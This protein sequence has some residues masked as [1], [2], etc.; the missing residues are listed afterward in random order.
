[1]KTHTDMKM[2]KTF[3]VILGITALCILPYSHINAQSSS[4]NGLKAYSTGIGLRGGF[5][6]GLSVKHFVSDKAAVE[7]II[8]SRWHGF[9]LTGLYELHTRNALKVSSLSWEYGIG[10]RVGFYDGRYYRGW[11]DK[12]YY[13]DRNYTAVSIVG[14]FGLEYQFHEIP[15]TV[16][17]DIMPY[18]DITGR[19]DSWIDGSLSFRYIF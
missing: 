12:V 16:G 13:D 3:A 2:I 11:K 18:A 10:A 1:M 4:Q 5:T 15:F 8:G 17:L 7:G 19:S 14:I 9:S 6:S